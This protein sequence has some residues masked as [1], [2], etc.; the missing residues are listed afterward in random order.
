MRNHQGQTYFM[1]KLTQQKLILLFLAETPGQWVKEWTL[2]GKATPY[3][4]IGD[5]AKKRCRE[6][7][8]F[9]ADKAT[10]EHAGVIYELE[11]SGKGKYAT[12]RVA[13]AK[14]KPKLTPRFIDKPDGSR[15]V[16]LTL[17]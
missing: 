1:K 4:F 5:E 7:F 14:A 9:G 15:V 17:I 2:R 10:Y 13:S 11:R 8:E 16:Q 12:I 6:F 3:G